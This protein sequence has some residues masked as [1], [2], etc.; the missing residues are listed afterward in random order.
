MVYMILCLLVTA[1]VGLGFG[2]QDMIW[3]ISLSARIIGVLCFGAGIAAIVGALC[4]CLLLT[5]SIVGARER[6][7]T[8]TAM[9]ALVVAGAVAGLYVDLAIV[10][11]SF[12]YNRFKAWFFGI[13]ALSCLALAVAAIQM[14]WKDISRGVKF[15]GIVALLTVTSQF[16]YQNVYLPENVDAGI[17]HT[18]TVG[19][20]E[21]IGGIRLVT[22]KVTMENV[23]PVA[24]LSVNSMIV[25]RGITYKTGQNAKDMSDVATQRRMVAYAEYLG[26]SQDLSSARSP[27][28]RFEESQDKSILT[29]IRPIRIGIS[30][31]S[32]D[33]YSRDF[34]VVVPTPS[35]HALEVT[36]DLEVVPSTRMQIAQFS[37]ARQ[38][39]FSNCH[40]D[41][42]FSTRINESHLRYFATGPLVL[43]SDWC[44][45][46]PDPSIDI[47]VAPEHRRESPANL[48][49]IGLQFIGSEIY[50]DD[51][52]ALNSTK[53]R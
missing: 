32:H 24:V 25:V 33:T 37:K 36:S 39:R 27:N 46:L 29:I 40:N 3:A 42:R 28:V 1:I 51:T 10:N 13:L 30:L 50:R 18:I 20:V 11:Y 17:E 53:G 26:S 45:N 44:P 9:W 47:L 16:W 35:I 21:R 5:R 48:N 41:E 38:I 14:I 6:A 12:E 15:A 49:S 8:C 22:L 19:S 43:Y 2:F 7:T 34:V 52:F 31:D 23:S 4:L